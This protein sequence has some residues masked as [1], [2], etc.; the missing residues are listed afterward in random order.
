M[1]LD[2]AAAVDTCCFP[3]LLMRATFQQDAIA[4]DA[5]TMLHADC[6][7]RRDITPFLFFFS[8]YADVTAAIAAAALMPC[9]TLTPTRDDMPL[10]DAPCAAIIASCHATLIFSLFR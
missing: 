6:C 8:A 7:R 5:D 2:I 4:I 9:H 1:L 3:E 10:C